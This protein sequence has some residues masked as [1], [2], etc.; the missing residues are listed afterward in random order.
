[1]ED[2]DIKVRVHS[3]YEN[4]KTFIETQ[5]REREVEGALVLFSGYMDST[6]VSKLAIDALGQDAVQV[7]LRT[8]KYVENQEEVFKESIAFL[9]ISEEKII[10]CDIEKL[11]RNYGAENLSIPGSIREIPSLY[12]PLSYSLLKFAARKEI[13]GK[14]YGMVGKASSDRERLIHKIIAYSKLRSRLHMS[15]AY[16]NAETKNLFLF[17]TINKTE[18][19]TGLFT[20]WG[21][22]HAADLM[23]LGNLYR[24]QVFQLAEYLEIPETIRGLAKADL[25]PGIANKYQYFFN[26]DAI[27]VDRILVRLENG[28]DS[29]DIQKETGFSEESIDKIL[30]YFNSSAYTRAAP[31]IPKI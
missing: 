26:M 24:S 19:L 5:V 21:H 22:G 6:V 9:D 10:S 15:I 18:L 17:G 29:K 2:L 1:M 23:P 30:S 8:D 31:L 3:I 11:M 4:L 7:I 28:L 12:Q 13:E 27:D 20:K 16:L 14:T 25:L